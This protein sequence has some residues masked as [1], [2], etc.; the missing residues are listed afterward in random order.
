VIQSSS[1]PATRRARHAGG[2]RLELDRL[3]TRHRLRTSPY[4]NQPLCPGACE[5]AQHQAKADEP[6][7]L[8]ECIRGR[9]VD[10]NRDEGAGA[11]TGAAAA[12]WW[13]RRTR[14]QR[15]FEDWLCARVSGDVLVATLGPFRATSASAQRKFQIE[16]S[17]A[18]NA[19]DPRRR[20][21]ARDFPTARMGRATTFDAGSGAAADFAFP[22]RTSPSRLL[23]RDGAAFPRECRAPVVVA[24]SPRRPAIRARSSHSA[25]QGSTVVGALGARSTAR[26][27][28]GRCPPSCTRR[29]C[30]RTATA[31]VL[32]SPPAAEPAGAPPPPP[33]A[34]PPPAPPPGSRRELVGALSLPSMKPTRRPPSLP[35]RVVDHSNPGRLDYPRKGGRRSCARRRRRAQAFNE[36]KRCG[37]CAAPVPTD[38]PYH[39]AASRSTLAARAA[40]IRPRRRARDELARPR[41][42]GRSI[43]ASGR[44]TT[45]RSARPPLRLRHARP[46]GPA[47][48]G[49]LDDT[50]PRAASS[51]RSCCAHRRGPAPRG[52]SAGD[53]PRRG[54]ACSPSSAS[55]STSGASA[56]IR[57]T[58][59]SPPL[60]EAGTDVSGWRT[61]RARLLRKDRARITDEPRALRRRAWTRRR[62]RARRRSPA[63]TRA[64]SSKG[65]TTARPS[66]STAPRSG[67]SATRDR[68]TSGTSAAVAELAASRRPPRAGAARRR[69]RRSRWTLEAG[70]PHDRPDRRG[71]HRPR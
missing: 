52:R 33:P 31:R 2:R 24:T 46:R 56:S 62:R 66:G 21:V 61:I 17:C 37:G 69:P 25:A 71:E 13:R 20:L 34:P 40:A 57:R 8:G 50:R 22:A 51:S 28:R 63:P 58:R 18:R 32:V 67:A 49:E 19:P 30:R 12:P 43:L 65:S 10:E 54:A 47:R 41:E 16:P 1:T 45:G 14:R 27:A 44:R 60:R 55:R 36:R 6:L 68:R 38:H 42:R 23:T 70:L 5:F 11:R 3:G 15:R 29:H 48:R 53:A 26:C 64:P 9:H 4:G 39:P 59:A 7:L 35:V